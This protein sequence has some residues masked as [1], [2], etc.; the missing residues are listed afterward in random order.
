MAIRDIYQEEIQETPARLKMSYEEF[1][2]REYPVDIIGNGQ[3][4]QDLQD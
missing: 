3:D 1:L 4:L 2:R